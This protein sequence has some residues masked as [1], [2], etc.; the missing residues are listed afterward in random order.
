MSYLSNLDDFLLNYI[1]KLVWIMH[2]N[3]VLDEF[4]KT[5]PSVVYSNGGV[6]FYIANKKNLGSSIHKKIN[7]VS[8]DEQSQSHSIT[9]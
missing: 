3:D 5:F 8:S 1:Y 6:S 7:R 4:K 9:H 2:M